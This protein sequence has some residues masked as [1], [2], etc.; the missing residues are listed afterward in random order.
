MSLE[1]TRHIVTCQDKGR[2]ELFHAT[3]DEMVKWMHSND[4]DPEIVTLAK[5]YLRRRG[6]ST[7]QLIASPFLPSKY[8]LLVK[9]HEKLG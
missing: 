2:T 1:E 9:Y 8:H 4:T 7:V 3:V 6:A 5:D